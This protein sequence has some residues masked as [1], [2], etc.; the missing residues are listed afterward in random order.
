MSGEY[1]SY[2]RPGI[3]AMEGYTPGEQPKT[4]D[5][6]KLNTNE[7]PFPPAPGV[8]QA[9]LDFETG[10]LRRYPDPIASAL[11]K[12][13]AEM[14]GYGPENIIAGNGSDDLLTILTRCFT[15]ETRAMACFDP[16]YS[17]YPTLAKLQG[18]RCIRIPLTDSFGL[19][20]NVPDQA[21]GANLFFIA[22]PNAPTGNSFAKEKIEAICAGFKGIVVIDEAYADFAED[23]CMDLPRKYAN[24]VVTRTF[25]KSRSLAGLRFAFAVAHP[26]IIEG[27]MK[28][29]DSYNVSML[30]QV[31]AMASLRD[32]AYFDGCV[33]K[34]K[35]NRKQLA[36]GLRAFG[37]EILPSETNFLFVKP[38]CAAK[39]Y[40]TELKRRN[41]FVR[42]FSMERTCAY[43][44]I[45]VGSEPEIAALLKATG[46]ILGK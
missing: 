19:P 5:V 26:K 9:L 21:A 27:M 39:D 35:A 14:N 16:S 36:D 4:A 44:R 13:F 46:E 25:S 28:M 45:T 11:L 30:T 12:E 18:A 8:R 41:I 1:I 33:A 3:D 34:I 42:Y 20:E 40:F 24:T 31:L 23:N 17:L 22:R 37:F 7:S 38:P 15:D 10:R 6:I 29:K 32:K 2:F 43:V